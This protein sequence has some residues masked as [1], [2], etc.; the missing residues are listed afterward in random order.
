MPGGGVAEEDRA[1]L[2]HGIV[3]LDAIPDGEMGGVEVAGVRSVL[4][5]FQ[6]GRMDQFVPSAVHL[7]IPVQGKAVEIV[8]DLFSDG[9][10]QEFPVP[11]GHISA[12]AVP[13]GQGGSVIHIVI[14]GVPQGPS[15]IYS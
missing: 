3:G 14:D 2:R 11:V 5:V 13:V 1:A 6:R 10:S 12:V 9:F 7:E 15:I 8:D 4:P